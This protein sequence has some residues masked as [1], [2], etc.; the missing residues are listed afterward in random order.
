MVGQVEGAL[1]IRRA[2]VG[3][4]S[5]C[6]Y[7]RV[8]ILVRPAPEADKPVVRRLLELNSHD[9][10]AIDGRG[11]GP[12]GEYGY[13]YLDHYWDP[14]ENRHP[15]LVTVDGEIAGCVLVRAGTPHEF[16]EFFIVRKHRRRSV[17][18]TAAR[19]VLA[20]FPG[21]WLVH[22]I[23]GNDDAVAFWRRAIPYEF[24]EVEDDDGTGQWFVV[25]T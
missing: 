3:A 24:R 23:R 20:L 11:L 9:F 15:F 22:E 12:H 17:G 16:G 25:P 1:A 8:E 14:S 19:S 6:Q 10:S 21:E 4:G 7:V 5:G 13:S 2:P 18:T